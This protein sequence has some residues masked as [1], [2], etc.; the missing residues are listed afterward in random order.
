MN[1]KL[2]NFTPD[3]IEVPLSQVLRY[4]GCPADAG[5]EMT[6][7]ALRA[8]GGFKPDYK[9]CCRMAEVVTTDDGAFIGTLFAPGRDIAK[10]LENC[11]RAVVFAATVG[12]DCDRQKTRAAVTS[13][14]MALALDAAGSAAAEALCDRLCQDW[15]NEFKKIGLF[16]RPRFSPGY[17]DMPL[18][19]QKPLLEYLDAG[20]C[21]GVTLTNGML[22]TPTKTVTAIA[23]LG[24]A[25]CE[26]DGECRGCGK[27]DCI[28]KLT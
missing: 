1:F 11:Q 19:F 9:A 4:M 27:A 20:R 18:D 16:L 5:E 12:L 6:S 25:G 23:G 15:K 8:I 22:M 26:R 17:G 3:S 7:L 28:F 21:I 24:G 14:A 2:Y 10:N 13:Q